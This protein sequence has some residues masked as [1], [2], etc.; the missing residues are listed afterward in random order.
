MKYAV[1]L[2]QASKDSMNQFRINLQNHHLSELQQP[3]ITRKLW[4]SW[5]KLLRKRQR[6]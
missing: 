5:S 1:Y 2:E 3:E 4:A 6:K